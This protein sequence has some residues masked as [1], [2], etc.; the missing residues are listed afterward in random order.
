MASEV[1]NCKI[2]SCGVKLS[3]NRIGNKATVH[4]KS[5]YTTLKVAALT[6]NEDRR[7]Q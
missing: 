2:F 6:V 3:G 1:P 5:K 7:Q 4:T